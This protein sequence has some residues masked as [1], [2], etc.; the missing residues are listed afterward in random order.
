ME[1]R[2]DRESYSK[3]LEAEDKAD[4]LG[5]FGELLKDLNLDK[6]KTE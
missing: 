4:K 6:N 5:T 3:F 2:A 1:E